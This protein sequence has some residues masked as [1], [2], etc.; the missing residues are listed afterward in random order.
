M[1]EMLEV[2]LVLPLPVPVT[3]TTVLAPGFS[4]GK[5][6]VEETDPEAPVLPL[7]PQGLSLLEFPPAPH[8]IVIAPSK[9]VVP[10]EPPGAIPPAPIDTT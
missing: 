9:L 3:L 1:P 5:L 7:L 4:S 10:P 6:V 8:V 2:F